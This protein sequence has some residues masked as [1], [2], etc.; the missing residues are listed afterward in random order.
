MSVF[1]V[2]T[3]GS[4]VLIGTPRPHRA[5]KTKWLFSWATYSRKELQE[6][7]REKRLPST[8]LLEGEDP[9]GGLGRVM[10]EQLGVTDYTA[11]GPRVFSYVAPS[12][13]YPGYNHWDLAFVYD[14]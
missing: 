4:K 14:V 3:K 11:T 13:W 7:Y 5:W 1:A 8:Y 10:R 2:V 6:A 12:D 9:K